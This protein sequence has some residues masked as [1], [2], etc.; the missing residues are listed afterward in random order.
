MESEQEHLKRNPVLQMAGVEDAEEILIL[1]KLC[2]QS[3]AAL[4]NDD[5]IPPLTQ[6]LAELL[7]E[8]VT[9]CVLKIVLNG[10]IIG[11]VRAIAVEGTCYIGRL[12]VHPKFQG[13]GLGTRLMSRIELEFG[14]ADR[15]EIF[16][17]SRS[18]DNL[19]LYEHLGYREVR[20]QTISDSLDLVY[21]QKEPE[22]A[23]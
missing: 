22:K 16:T 19:R 14:Y 11:S 9:C 12:I 18:L 8:L 3:E 21:M 2:F 17:G 15:F 23:T 5:N 10:Q 13:R 1:Q 7:H 20:R 6:T 4:N